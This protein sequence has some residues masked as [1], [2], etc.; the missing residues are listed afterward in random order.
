MLERQ[1]I[2]LDCLTWIVS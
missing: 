1:F 2:V